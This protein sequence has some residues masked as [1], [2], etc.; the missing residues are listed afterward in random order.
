MG[1]VEKIDSGGRGGVCNFPGPG[2]R[3]VAGVVKIVGLSIYTGAI[4][5]EVEVNAAYCR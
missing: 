4:P 3:K 1:R 5:E 2:V